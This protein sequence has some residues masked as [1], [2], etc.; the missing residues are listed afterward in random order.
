M[1]KDY[2]PH[3]FLYGFGVPLHIYDKFIQ[4]RQKKFKNCFPKNIWFSYHGICPPQI[5]VFIAPVNWF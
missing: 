3:F 2:D 5:K 1:T 4:K